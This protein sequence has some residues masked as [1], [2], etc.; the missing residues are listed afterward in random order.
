MN[1]LRGQFHMTRCLPTNPDIPIASPLHHQP[2]AVDIPAECSV[3]LPGNILGTVGRNV[4][5]FAS[6]QAVVCSAVDVLASPH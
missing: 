4:R 6:Q 3:P 1:K 5:S 2:G